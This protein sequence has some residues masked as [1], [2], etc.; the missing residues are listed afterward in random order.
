[1]SNTDAFP[2]DEATTPAELYA[3]EQIV[4]LL[5][6]ELK[7]L[8]KKLYLSKDEIYSLDQLTRAYVNIMKDLRENVKHNTFNQLLNP[9]GDQETVD[10][11]EN[12][13]D[14]SQP[15]SDSDRPFGKLDGY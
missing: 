3:R 14:G 4:Y 13:A 11:H 2:L 1:M 6:R 12:T 15:T 10:P 8:R 7:N 5:N 9:R